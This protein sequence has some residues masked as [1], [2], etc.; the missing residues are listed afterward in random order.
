MHTKLGAAGALHAIVVVGLGAFGAH[1]MTGFTPD[2]LDTFEIG[3]RYHMYHA[4]GL[5]IIAFAAEHIGYT[6]MLRWAGYLMHIGIFFFSGSIYLLVLTGEKFLGPITPIGGFLFVIA[7]ALLAISF[8]KH[9]K[10]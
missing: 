5:M 7:W 9:K 6:K 2:Q 1:L 8:W 10:A 3:V 4:I